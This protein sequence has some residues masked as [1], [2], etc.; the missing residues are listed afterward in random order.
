MKFRECCT[1][2]LR[3]NGLTD[4]M[5]ST[6]KEPYNPDVISRRYKPHSRRKRPNMLIRTLLLIGLPK[7]DDSTANSC[8]CDF[9]KDYL[10][11]FASII[12]VQSLDSETKLLKV[13]IHESTKLP[14][15]LTYQ[16]KTV[17]LVELFDIGY[18]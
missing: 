6:K 2:I 13:T 4:I 17:H 11:V 18:Q 10:Q 5:Q 8:D 14:S 12:D 1:Q 9:I 15:Y 7:H 16:G 3:E